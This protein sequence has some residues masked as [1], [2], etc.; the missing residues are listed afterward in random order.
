MK[1]TKRSS[2]GSYF[3][4]G[5]SGLLKRL[6]AGAVARGDHRDHLLAEP[7]G[8]S[9]DDERVSDVRMRAQ[10]GLDFL[11]EDLLAAGVHHERV[12]P[13]QHEP[14]VGLHAGAITRHGDA[15]PVDERERRLGGG[16]VVEVA[17]WD[18]GRPREPADLVVPTPRP[19]ADG[20]L[21]DSDVDTDESVAASS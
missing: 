7:L 5:H 6:Q 18:V 12:A 20:P 19:K 14:A 15:D 21:A 9:A 2:G 11:D 4:F 13:Q 17:E 3:F 10:N 1:K 8:G 16:R